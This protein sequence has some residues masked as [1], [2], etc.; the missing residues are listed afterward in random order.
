MNKFEQVSGL[1]HQM[2]LAWGRAGGSLYKGGQGLGSLYSEVMV[3]GHM[4]TARYQGPMFELSSH[5]WC[6]A[7]FV[8]FIRWLLSGSVV[9]LREE[10]R[11]HVS[12]GQT[13]E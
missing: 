3:N 1:G 9:G 12:T 6:Y 4:V 8:T 5:L 11:C 13:A 10:A 2:S 7:C